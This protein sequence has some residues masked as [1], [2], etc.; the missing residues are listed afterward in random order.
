MSLEE[1]SASI[2]A[3]LKT[4]YEANPKL[5]KTLDENKIFRS[6]PVESIGQ[7]KKIDILKRGEGGNIME[8]VLVGTDATI[9]VLTEYNIRFLLQP[10]QH[11]KGKDNIIL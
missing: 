7:L 6:R 10:K 2:N 1:L 3:N 11:I 4:R 5:I 9:K 8:M